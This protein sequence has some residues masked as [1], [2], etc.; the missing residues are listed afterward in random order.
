MVL[1]MKLIVNDF[2]I[3][4][5]LLSTQKCPLLKVLFILDTSSLTSEQKLKL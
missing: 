2:D 1:Y 5:F 4:N 3:L